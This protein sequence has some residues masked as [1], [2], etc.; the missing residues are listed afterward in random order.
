MEQDRELRNRP[1]HTTVVGIS[2]ASWSLLG[3]LS[4]RLHNISERLRN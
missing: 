3:G 1:T 2:E 4:I